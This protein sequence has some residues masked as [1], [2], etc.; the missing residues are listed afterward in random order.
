VDAEVVNA[1]VTAIAEGH[2][3]VEGGAVLGHGRPVIGG[4][5]CGASVRLVG[6]VVRGGRA[7]LC[8][9]A[10]GGGAQ[11]AADA[12]PPLGGRRIGAVPRGL[13]VAPVADLFGRVVL[14]DEAVL[15]V[16]RVLVAAALA[17]LGGARVVGV[18]QVGGHLSDE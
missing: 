6:A 17:E 2:G 12:R 15:E 5:R 13:V 7:R 1:Q 3:G 16:V 8:S 18:A 11:E 14:A 9:R 4:R 10:S